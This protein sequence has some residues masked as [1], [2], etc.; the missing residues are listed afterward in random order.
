MITPTIR[1]EIHGR[2]RTRYPN[3]CDLD[4]PGGC[5]A[6]R[7]LFADHEGEPCFCGHVRMTHGTHRDGGCACGCPTWTSPAGR[8]ELGATR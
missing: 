7:C 1:A 3:G 8:L 5:D 4:H 6:E 2:Y